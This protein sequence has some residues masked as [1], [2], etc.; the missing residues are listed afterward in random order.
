MTQT[1]FKKQK[2][3]LS[4]GEQLGIDWSTETDPKIMDYYNTYLKDKTSFKRSE[5]DKHFE[6]LR[7]LKGRKLSAKDIEYNTMNSILKQSPIYN[8]ST[9]TLQMKN[10]MT[11]S[12][13]KSVYG[14]MPEFKPQDIKN[15]DIKV[16]K[17][18]LKNDPKAIQQRI[19]VVSQLLNS[20]SDRFGDPLND[21]LKGKHEKLTKEL[22]TLLDNLDKLTYDS[23]KQ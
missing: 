17:E 2:K 1:I 23:V 13:Y 22:E 8:D 15:Y 14:N 4:L 16:Y 9:T 19:K 18:S 3:K 12:L 21:K 11:D 20:I 10:Q 5:Y 6:N 7:K